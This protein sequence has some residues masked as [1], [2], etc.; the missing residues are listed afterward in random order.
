MG[1]R[2]CRTFAARNLTETNRIRFHSRP[3]DIRHCHPGSAKYGETAESPP[4]LRRQDESSLLFFPIIYRA[5]VSTFFNNQD[6]SGGGNW[7]PFL[8]NSMEE[9]HR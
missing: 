6:W 9:V 8:T 7:V 1:A 3:T 4:A 2:D 5:E